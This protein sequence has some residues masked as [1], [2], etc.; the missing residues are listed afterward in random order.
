MQALVYL[1][2][3]KTQEVYKSHI[4]NGTINKLYIFSSNGSV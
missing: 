2:D 1:S 3:F 4:L